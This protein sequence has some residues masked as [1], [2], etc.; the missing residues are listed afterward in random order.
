MV[1]QYYAAIVSRGLRSFLLCFLLLVLSV[2]LTF[3]SASLRAQGSDLL[4]TESFVADEATVSTDVPDEDN[5]EAVA[6]PSSASISDSGA[7]VVEEV[8]ITGSL[9]PKGNYASSAPIATIT[10][11][12]FEITNTVNVEQ[13]LN[14]MPQV[15]AGSDRSSTFGFGWATADLRG[16]GQNRTL[17][18]L[19][20]KRVTP[21]FPDGGTVDLNFVPPGLIERIEILTGGASTTYGSDAMAGVINIITRDNFEGFELVAGGE[22]TELGDGE[23]YNLSAMWG[24]SFGGGRGHFMVLGDISERTSIK[25]PDRDFS[26]PFNTET[27]DENGVSQGFI[28]FLFP[29]SESGNIF[30]MMPYQ[31]TGG[32]DVGPYNPVTQG[33]DPTPDFLL[34][35]PQER[36]VLFSRVRWEGDRFSLFGQIHAADT[37]TLRSFVAPPVGPNNLGGPV[38]ITLENNPFISEQGINTLASDPFVQFFGADFNGNG[39]PDIANVFFGRTM[40]EFG[41]ASQ[42]TDYEFRQYQLGG[43]FDLDDYWS[44][45]AYVN[46]G[47]VKSDLTITGAVDIGRVKQ[48]LLLDASGTACMDPSNGC[49]PANVYGANTLSAE[50]VNFL[51]TDVPSANESDLTQASVLLSGNTGG[52]FEMPGGAGPLG[53]AIGVE[54]IKREQNW[55]VDERLITGEVDIP[56]AAPEP[57]KGDFTRKAVYGEL[58]VPLLSGRAYADFLELELAA[59]YTDYSNLE[60]T[61][62]AK[63]AVSYYPIPDVQIRASF[64]RAVRAAALFELYGDT[65]EQFNLTSGSGVV[66]PCSANGAFLGVDEQRCIDTGVP[67]GSV[68]SPNLNLNPDDVVQVNLFS[69]PNLKAETGDT[70]SV[71]VV[72]TPYEIDGL[73][74]SVDY[75]QVEVDDYIARL[76]GGGAEGI[77]YCY[78]GRD[79]FDSEGIAQA[80]CPQIQRDQSGKLV[81]VDAGIDNLA[82]HSVKGVDLSLNHRFNLFNGNLDLYFIG[83]YIDE[84][85]YE[86]NPRYST[87]C[88][89][90]FNSPVGAESC[91]RPVTRW[92]HRATATWT[93][94]GTTLQLT[95]RGISGVAD[96]DPTR[97][98]AVENIGSQNYF[99]AAASHELSNGLKLSAG[100]RNLTDEDPPVLG[101]NSFEANTYP[102]IYDIYGRVYY[103]RIQYNF[104]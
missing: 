10:N 82:T 91:Q 31:F 40:A 94:G 25:Y 92:K 17:T 46:T 68:G 89:G 76:P 23:I 77:E 4:E 85:P 90:K 1:D 3:N 36:E 28:P 100:V 42:L 20:G 9:L 59:R 7:G 37:Y 98:Y 101:D 19:D 58:V 61:T 96:N 21:T 39:I 41:P 32:G 65:G 54:Y 6:S 74:V 66:D 44:I 43:V 72:W 5:S 2:S 73:S 102:N 86:V 29:V 78:F 53:A 22:I 26:S 55:E 104:D 75:F 47:T 45:D 48:A 13:L 52:F 95:W 88:A 24:T 80:Y 62:A 57:F 97:E 30:G 50:A 8:F 56:W 64:N 84:K 15:L 12:Q 83:T 63:V 79:G 67:A 69:N 51:R 33:F 60:S 99:E 81:R 14:T 16:L 71:G 27:Y 49:V 34:Q 35:I 11:Q 38:P 70:Y 103:G 18:L 93:K 87:D